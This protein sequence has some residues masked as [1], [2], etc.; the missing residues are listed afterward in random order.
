MVGED[1]L[2]GV[3]WTPDFAEDV[4]GAASYIED[5]LKSPRAAQNLYAGI[6]ERLDSQRTMPTSATARVGPDG[7]TY[8]IVTYKNWDIYYIID[9]RVIAAVALKH[10]L[11][12]G[13]RV[14]LPKDAEDL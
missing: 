10:H 5:V 1:G 9:G 8:Y 11:Q 6:E 7:A 14:V 13:G 2:Y 3:E 12:S 4:V